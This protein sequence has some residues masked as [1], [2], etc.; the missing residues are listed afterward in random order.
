M[1]SPRHFLRAR[2]LRQRTAGS[3]R[4]EAALRNDRSESRTAILTNLYTFWEVR[5]PL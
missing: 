3:S 2:A 1:P 4:D 5:A